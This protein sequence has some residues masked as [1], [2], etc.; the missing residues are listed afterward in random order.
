LTASKITEI[1][2]LSDRVGVIIVLQKISGGFGQAARQ[3]LGGSTRQSPA[4][5]LMVLAEVFKA[6]RVGIMPLFPI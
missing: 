1:L 5:V 6:G 3:L 2:T 4:E